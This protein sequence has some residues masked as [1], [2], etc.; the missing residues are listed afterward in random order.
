MSENPTPNTNDSST[1]NSARAAMLED[2]AYDARWIAEQITHALLDLDQL[3]ERVKAK[4]E[5]ISKWQGE[6]RRLALN[7]VDG[8]R[9]QLSISFTKP[10]PK[11]Q[12]EPQQEVPQTGELG[13][14]PP[15]GDTLPEGVASPDE[16]DPETVP[17]TSSP[18][19]EKRGKK[20][21]KFVKRPDVYACSVCG[22]EF[23]LYEVLESDFMVPHFDEDGEIAS[24]ECSPECAAQARER[25]G[26]RKSKRYRL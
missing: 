3:K 13:E 10:E 24:M 6:L 19:K 25:A 9:S 16:D 4:R 18:Q 20:K 23:G 14:E 8:E 2:F 5:E 7:G 21:R 12:Q 1:N 17:T 15:S 26:S 11:A 22:K